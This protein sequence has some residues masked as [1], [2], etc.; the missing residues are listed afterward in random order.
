[1]NRTI[2]RIAAGSLLLAGAGTAYA[3][4]VCIDPTTQ[5]VDAAATA[6]WTA[7]L[8][9]ADT[10]FMAELAGTWVGPA[11]DDPADT[12]STLTVD[13]AA[14]GTLTFVLH[15]CGGPAAADPCFDLA[16]TGTWTAYHLADG[17]FVFGRMLT[18]PGVLQAVCQSDVVTLSGPDTATTADGIVVH[19]LPPGPPATPAK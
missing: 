6:T 3:Q 17:T 5:L 18:A 8:A 4:E 13:Y 12:R 9:K 7:D 11:D 15:Q 14:D 16:G 1:M 19:R 2:I 10:A